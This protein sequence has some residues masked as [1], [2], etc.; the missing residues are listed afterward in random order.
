METDPVYYVIP[1]PRTLATRFGVWSIV[2][3]AISVIPLFIP[4][5]FGVIGIVLGTI[6]LTLQQSRTRTS[7]TLNIIG[8][9]LGAIGI[10][11]N[12]IIFIII[13][14]TNAT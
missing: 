8:I 11:F 5:M 14:A 6:G 3:G 1:N 13:A 10:V 4:A 12:I 9:S 2:L 7:Q